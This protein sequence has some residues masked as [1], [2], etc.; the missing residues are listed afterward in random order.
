[1]VREGVKGFQVTVGRVCHHLVKGRMPL[2]L[3]YAEGS[4]CIFTTVSCVAR[5]T[6]RK[7]HV[8]QVTNTFG[9]YELPPIML[10]S[11][12]VL[13]FSVKFYILTQHSS[14]CRGKPAKEGSAVPRTTETKTRLTQDNGEIINSS[15]K[16]IRTI[17]LQI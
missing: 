6:N 12:E 4:L 14:V 16:K 17:D 7:S 8:D 2:R 10:G 11:S 13:N 5:C 15:I 3:L 1:M 9:A